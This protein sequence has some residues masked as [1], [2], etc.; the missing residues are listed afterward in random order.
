METSVQDI[1]NDNTSGS[2]EIL[3]KIQMSLLQ[4]SKP[5]S[6]IQQFKS[7]FEHFPIVTHF[8]DYLKSR[9]LH[10]KVVDEYNA[11]WNKHNEITINEF[12]GSVSSNNTSVMVH[13]NSGMVKHAILELYRRDSKVHV[14]QTESR[15]AFEGLIQGAYFLDKGIS[16]ELT[17][18][19][20][21]VDAMKRIDFVLLGADIILNDSIVNKLGSYVIALAADSFD[22]PVYILADERKK[23]SESSDH[24]QQKEYDP[25]EVSTD[26]RF[27]IRN[28]YFETVPLKFLTKIYL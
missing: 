3:R 4:T 25:S 18:D 14:I 27:K 24:F 26:S 16:T 13:S 5:A 12:V 1:L 6:A 11:Q 7:Q 28:R 20:G 15:P 17:I 19:A 22:T 8:L 10:Q 23:V 9:N 2:S 21:I